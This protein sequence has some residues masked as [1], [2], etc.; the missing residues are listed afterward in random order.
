MKYKDK[1]IELADKAAAKKL[2]KEDRQG[3]AYTGY[4]FDI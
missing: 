2:K 4:E 1:L 3:A